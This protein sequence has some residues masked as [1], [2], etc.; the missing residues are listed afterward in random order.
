MEKQVK[1]EEIIAEMVSTIIL[2]CLNQSA[3][4]NC[5]PFCNL[6]VKI[7]GPVILIIA[8][9]AQVYKY[10]IALLIFCIRI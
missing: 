8:I 3:L 2:G 9:F 1:V 4:S 5:K 7:R 10:N 6:T